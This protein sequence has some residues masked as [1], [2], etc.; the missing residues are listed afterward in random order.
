MLVSVKKEGAPRDLRHLPVP[1]IIPT[2]G[3]CL[4]NCPHQT[5]RQLIRGSLPAAFEWI[6]LAFGWVLNV[7][8]RNLKI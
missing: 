3:D 2:L 8:I 6:G 4:Q 7:S 1:T 5:R